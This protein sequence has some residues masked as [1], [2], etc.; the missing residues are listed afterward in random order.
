MDPLWTSFMFYVS[1]N[2]IA[3][4]KK[5]N[6]NHHNEPAKQCWRTL[7]GDRWRLIMLDGDWWPLMALYCTWWHLMALDDTL[8]TLMALDGTWWHFMDLDGPWWHLLALDGPW[9]HFM[10][11]D[12]PWW[13][14]MALDGT[15]WHLMANIK[16]H[17][18]PPYM[19]NM[20]DYSLLNFYIWTM[21]GWIMPHGCY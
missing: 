10:A 19:R 7:N 3:A 9:W 4:T 1:F 5:H 8:W 20:M 11:L 14:L 16:Y 21:H 12:G 15:W 18:T 13:P 2:K 6:T 17:T